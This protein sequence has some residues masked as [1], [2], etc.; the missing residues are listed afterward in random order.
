MVDLRAPLNARQLE[1]LRWIGDGC[2]DGVMKDHTHKTSAAALDWRGLV[3]VS[4]KGGVWRAT[5][6]DSGH[7]YLKHGDFP[8][9]G[10]TP[11][12]RP[13]QPERSVATPAPKPK[14][15]PSAGKPPKPSVS[16]QL[17]AA[18]IAAGGVLT[19]DTRADKTDYEARVKAAN[20]WNKVPVGQQLVYQWADSSWR[21][22]EIR[23]E[24]L[25]AWRMAVLEPIPVPAMLHK[26]HPVVVALR[27]GEVIKGIK[28]ATTRQRALRLVQALAA[29]ATKRGYQ[30]RVAKNAESTYGRRGERQPEADLT[31]TMDGQA[32]GMA[33]RQ[34]IDRAKH[35]ATEAEMAHYGTLRFRWPP[36]YDET[37]TERLAIH[38]LGRFEHWQSE[39]SDRKGPLEDCLARILQEIELRAAAAEEA[40]LAAEEAARERR[41]QWE[42]AMAKAKVDH[43][44]A[45]RA[46]VLEQ[47]MVA[48]RHAGQLREYIVA[49]EERIASMDGAE[50]ETAAEWLSW[51][52]EHV[53]RVDPLGSRLAMPA[54]PEPKPDELKL[55]LGRWSP[56]GPET[57]YYG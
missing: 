31:V 1:V 6:T 32:V 25:P 20:R 51:A 21:M 57:G 3:A 38:V 27:D 4:K 26:A 39:W 41:R 17:V 5:I 43:R 9:A 22:R 47:Q 16:E 37:P 53:A 42:A 29:E 12:P 46:K 35:T 15:R 28:G 8:P 24:D 50:A 52:T 18:V 45:H 13:P 23:L 48:W 11:T 55:F 2:P 7:H 19:I 56:Y 34:E 10:Q 44:E 30:V 49:M 33:I 40:W 36:K 54:D 14:T